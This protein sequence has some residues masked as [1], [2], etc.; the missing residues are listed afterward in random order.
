MGLFKKSAVDEARRDTDRE[1]KANQ[2]LRD[3]SKAGNTYMIIRALKDGAN[4]NAFG[5]EG[6]TALMLAIEKKDGKVRNLLMKNGAK[7]DA[8]DSEGCT[9]LMHAA[10]ERGVDIIK[11][12]LEE[13]AR[14]NIWGNSRQTP[15]IYAA[16]GGNLG[17]IK[18]LIEKGAAIDHADKNGWTAL[19]WAIMYANEDTIKLLLEAGAN[20]RIVDVH[21]RDALTLAREGQE[22]TTDEEMIRII[23]L[24]SEWKIRPE[25]ERQEL[26]LRRKESVEDI[27][28]DLNGDV[29][30]EAKQDD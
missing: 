26:N 17:V 21:G 4:I 25:K 30:D 18:L 12:L 28:S 23:N 27:I 11:L 2:I 7:I 19:M 29:A 5:E 6:K 20:I 13:G 3:A 9:I 22:N 8:K 1:Q 15:L 14:V 10:E 16:R 24:I